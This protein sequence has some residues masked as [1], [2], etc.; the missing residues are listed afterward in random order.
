MIVTGRARLLLLLGVTCMLVGLVEYVAALVQFG[1]GVVTLAGHGVV[2][3]FVIARIFLNAAQPQ[4]AMCWIERSM[5][6]SCG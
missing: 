2:P 3:V 5:R 1:R 6:D 4:L